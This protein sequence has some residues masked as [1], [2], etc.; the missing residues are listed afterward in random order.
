[1][2][3]SKEIKLSRLAFIG[4]VALLIL[5][6]STSVGQRGPAPAPAYD[7]DYEPRSDT[8]S[9]QHD[10]DYNAEK[11]PL[12][13]LK[14]DKDPGAQ[15]NNNRRQDRTPPI[16]LANADWPWGE[17]HFGQTY[18]AK[19]ILKNECKSRETVTLTVNN[20]PYLSVPTQVH[21]PG[22]SMIEVE[23]TITT[24]PTPN[25]PLLTGHETIPEIGIFI[26]IPGDSESLVIWHPWNHPC[27]PKRETYKVSGHIHFPPE[28]AG[29]KP[30]AQK[31]ARASACQVYW[32]TG[33]K[34]GRSNDD[35]TEDL[36]ML[37][38]HYR[39]RVLQTYAEHDREAWSWLPPSTAIRTMSE[40]ELM[41]MKA[42]SDRQAAE[43]S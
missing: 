39:E 22:R 30:G 9:P 17:L 4:V 12:H 3:W 7:P 37:A 1:M 13:P 40:Q 26:D 18:K 2:K 25:V 35:C 41:A 34:P 6:V 15:W 43:Q 21:I 42:R 19:V 10:P 5:P 24:P 36:R 20:L 27:K 23:A 14:S 31:I 29:G 28:A 8:T 32:N 33:Q 16:L 11:D 38:L